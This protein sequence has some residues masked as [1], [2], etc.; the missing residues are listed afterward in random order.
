MS[1]GMNEAFSD[2]GGEATEFYWKGSNDFDVGRDIF[3]SGSG[4]LRYMC[5]P[6]APTAASID[7]AANYTSSLDVHYSSGVY[8]KAFCTL[9]KTAG[10]DTPKA[11]KVMAPRP[12][13]CTGPRAH[14]QPGCVRR[15]D[16]ATDL[17][18]TRPT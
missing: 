16:A 3:K 11:F 13:R 17:G 2:M 15:G 1:G 7:N 6:R 5:Q 8:N 12:T 9:A 18:L 10:W 14:L 4:A